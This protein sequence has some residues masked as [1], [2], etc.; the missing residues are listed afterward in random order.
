MTE[1][2][3]VQSDDAFSRK[4]QMARLDYAVRSPAA[5]QSLAE[6]YVGLPATADF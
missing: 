6:N 2:L 4:I 5:A 3:H 1:M